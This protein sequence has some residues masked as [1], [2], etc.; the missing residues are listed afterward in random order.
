MQRLAPWL[1]A[2][3][4]VAVVVVL[5]VMR[6]DRPR[7]QQAAPA[8]S[9][10]APSASNDPSPACPRTKPTRPGVGI[11]VDYVDFVY[12]HG[13]TYVGGIRRPGGP[14]RSGRPSDL[15]RA[16][17]R[18]SCTIV[19][20]NQDGHHEVVGPYREDNAAFLPV[21]T[22][23]RRVH[24]YPPRCRLAA[25]WQGHIRLYLLQRQV[26]HHDRIAKCALRP[27]R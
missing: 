1:A 9:S 10:P 8:Q 25:R 18:V 11:A 27:R 4:A 13:R 24:G 3:A 17:A 6:I 15:G 5:V 19:D 26:H 14:V 20:L 16:V 2:A 7:A 22:A 23:L 12:H 21:G